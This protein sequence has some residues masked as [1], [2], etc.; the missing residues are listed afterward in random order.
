MEKYD[1]VRL[2]MKEKWVV[3]VRPDDALAQKEYITAQDFSVLPLIIL[4]RRMGMQSELASW[5]GNYYEKLHVVFTS[6]LSTN[7]AVMVN[8]CFGL[9]KRRPDK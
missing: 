7:G 8:G 3:M 9:F 1:F 4:P 6:N 2:D 5:F